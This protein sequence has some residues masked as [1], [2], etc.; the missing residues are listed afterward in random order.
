M[1]IKRQAE[2]RQVVIKRNA[3]AYTEACYFDMEIRQIKC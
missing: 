1:D 2:Q 3:K